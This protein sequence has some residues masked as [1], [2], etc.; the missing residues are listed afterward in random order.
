MS[1]QTKNE[2]EKKG[3][4]KEKRRLFDATGKRLVR[5]IRPLRGWIALSAF[6]C[7]ILIGC[8]VA[9]PELLGGL[10]DKLYAWTKDHTPGLSRSLLPG[11]GLLLGIY[12]VQA[13][14]T[15]GNSYLLNNV[16]SRYFCAELRIRLSEKLRRLPVSYVDQTPAGDVIDR[17]MEDVGNM[18]DS[19]YGIVEI[20]LTGFLQMFVIAL[21][22]FL[23]DWRMAIPVVLLSPLSVWLSAKMATLGEK[24]WD[25]HFNLG[26]E[27]TALAEEAYT[28]YPATKAFNREAYL[29]EKYDDLSQRHQRNG[30]FGNFL[31]SIVQPVIV[32]VDALA[33]I[34][35]ALLGGWLIVHRG[36]PIGTVVTVI[37]FARQL[38]APLERIAFGLSYVQHVK[39]A[40]KRVFNLLD[41]PEEEDPAETAQAPT[42]G[43]VE[44]RNVDFS[45]DPEKPLIRNLSF[46]VQPGQKVAIVGPTGAGKTTIVN[47]L[48]RFYDIQKGQIL[49]DGED[50]SKLSRA[51]TR[52]RFGMVLQD[53]WLF[54]GTVAE[55]VAYGSPEATREEIE[56]ACDLAYCD[57]F[58]RRLPQG[59]DSVISEDSTAVSSGQKQLLTIAR[60]LLADRSLLILDEATSNVDTRTEL[61]IQKAMDRLMG[62]RTCFVIA[63]RL[64]TIVDAD[65]ILVIRDGQIVEQGTHRELLD[66]KGFYYELFNSQYKI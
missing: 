61:L 52:R 49:I 43:R 27:L 33:Y 4:A 17:M 29:Q 42:K 60:A 26:G 57:H 34:A 25:K 5:E 10:V 58:I 66:Q 59:Y 37:L 54:K 40:A 20:L 23:T 28:N 53:T 6:F 36:M 15:Y 46:S 62:G 31:S 16:V 3:E 1:T 7:L 48:M 47:L 45:Y 35:V 41:L 50:I 12:A 64:S 65:C 8:A 55:N 22:L 30:I 63:H 11:L 39:S 44:F 14:V 56:R 24:H 32:F 21:I 2:P 19:I 38:S 13:G 51:D 9:A 18:A